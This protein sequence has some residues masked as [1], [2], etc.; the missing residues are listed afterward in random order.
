RYKHP[1]LWKADRYRNT[2]GELVFQRITEEQKM[3]Q[4]SG[5]DGDKREFFEW[6]LHYNRGFGAHQV[7]GVI[8]YTQSSKV[9]TQNI[10]TDLKNGIARRNQGIAG[11][12][13]Y[14]WNYRY[15]IDFNFGYTG[16]ENFHKD[17]RFGFFPAVSGAWN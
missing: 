17:H 16:S 9:F 12:A 13:N 8:K 6:D 15:F 11:R 14:N 5:S 4:S 7:G 10:G 1:E 3:T 2:D